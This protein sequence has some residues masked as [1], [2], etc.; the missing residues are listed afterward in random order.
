MR[1]EFTR[2]PEN[3]N[4]SVTGKGVILVPKGIVGIYVRCPYYKREE[5][6]RTAKIVCEG[7]ADHTTLHMVF[8]S[9]AELKRYESFCCKG[10]WTQCPIAQMNNRKWDYEI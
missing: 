3:G 8:E 9:T 2:S 10:D 1:T 5:R 6:K 4:S 7:A